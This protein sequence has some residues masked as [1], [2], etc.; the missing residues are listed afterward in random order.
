MVEKILIAVFAGVFC[1]VFTTLV[2][3]LLTPKALKAM[4]EEAIKHHTEVWH[5]DSMY[6]YVEGE[7]VKHAD[8]CQAN[9]CI[10]DVKKAVFWLVEKNGG[11]IM[12]M[13]PN[14]KKGD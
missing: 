13:F 5:Q 9:Y 3:V 12:E 2:N 11:N 14:K 4:V 7:I 8:A 6:K 10:D 1:S